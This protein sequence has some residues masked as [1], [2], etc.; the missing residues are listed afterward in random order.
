MSSLTT[1]T[2][3]QFDNLVAVNAWLTRRPAN[4]VPVPMRYRSAEIFGDEKRLEALARTTLFGPG[5]LSLELL[6]C[7][8][9]APPLPAVSVGT[10]PDVL[11]VENSDPYWAAVDVLSYRDNHPVGAVIWGAGNSFPAQVGTLAVDVAGR[12]PVTGEIWYWGDFDPPGLAIATNAAAAAAE[13]DMGHLK[14]AHLLW[15]EMAGRP[16][17]NPGHCAWT[18]EVAESWLGPPLWERFSRVR[19][20]QGRIAQEAVPPYTIAEWAVTLLKE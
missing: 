10:G 15:E 7:V 4:V 6:A 12:G 18:G 11:V 14:P 20:E 5:R 3:T 9:R 19:A 16:T 13:L 8:R 17:Q 1:L 2:D